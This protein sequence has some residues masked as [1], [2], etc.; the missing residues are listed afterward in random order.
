VIACL[1]AAA[2]AAVAFAM[3]VP[4]ADLSPGLPGQHNRGNV[5]AAIGVMALVYG[6]VALAARLALPH[7]ATPVAVAAGL[8]VALGSV[9]QLRRDAAHWTASAAAQER[10]LAAVGRPPRGSTVFTFRAPVATGPNVPVFAAIWDLR[11]ALALRQHDPTLNAYPVPP[12][13]RV[14]C[15]RGT[16]ELD[17]Y[18]DAFARQ[19]ARYADAVLVDVAAQRRLVPPGPRACRE[20]AGLTAAR[21]P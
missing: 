6:L 4:S 12:D 8:L 21:A 15:D 11:G 10:V 5:A 13:T 18:N 9:V 17:N 14:R 16:I 2:A 19:R 3:Q 7:R 1:A 20:A